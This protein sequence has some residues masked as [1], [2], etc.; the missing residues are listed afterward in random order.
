MSDVRCRIYFLISDF[1]C[2]MS[3]FFLFRMFDVGFI[4]DFG[5][6][7]WV[8]ISDVGCSMSDLFLISDVGFGM[9]DLI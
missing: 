1:G 8:L 9:S 2:S 7:M 4:F 6:R 3:D 5:F